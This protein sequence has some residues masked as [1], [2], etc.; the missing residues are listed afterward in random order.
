MLPVA[1][2]KPVFFTP[3]SDISSAIQTITTA[4]GLYSV[5]SRCHAFTY[6]LISPFFQV[7]IASFYY[8]S[9]LNEAIGYGIRVARFFGSAA[10]IAILDGCP[11]ALV[12]NRM[13]KGNKTISPHS[14]GSVLHDPHLQQSS[15]VAQFSK[16]TVKNPFNVTLIQDL[17]MQVIFITIISIHFKILVQT[18]FILVVAIILFLNYLLR[19]LQMAKAASSQ[20]LLVVGSLHCCA[21]WQDCGLLIVDQSICQTMLDRKEFFSCPNV[22][23]LQPKHRM[24]ERF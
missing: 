21:S 12:L 3:G 22:C 6:H 7:V 11:N 15:V 23:I 18:P 5:G 9:A 17:T 10:A 4:G 13:G 14:S 19:R 2:A 1:I 8:V 20:G 16:V 24:F